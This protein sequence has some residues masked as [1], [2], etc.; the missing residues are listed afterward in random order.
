M[1]CSRL[2]YIKLTDFPLWFPSSVQKNILTLKRYCLYDLGIDYTEFKFVFK[3]A[4]IKNPREKE[5]TV[6]SQRKLSNVDI[7]VLI[8]LLVLR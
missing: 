4:R 7:I 6:C 8:S 1:V 2:G 3:K 5:L